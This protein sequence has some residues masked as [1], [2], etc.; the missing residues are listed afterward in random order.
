MCPGGVGQFILQG[1]T[2]VPWRGRQFILQGKTHV[3]W[4]GR[5]FILQ[6]KTNVPWKGRRFILQGKTRVPWR[7]RAIHTPLVAFVVLLM[8]KDKRTYLWSSVASHIY[9]IE[10]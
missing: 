6:G 10:L 9:P 7:G 4:R 2:H 3:L 8:L 1:K 5:Q